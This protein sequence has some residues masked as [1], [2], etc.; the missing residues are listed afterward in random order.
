VNRIARRQRRRGKIKQ[1]IRFRLRVWPYLCRMITTLL[2]ADSIPHRLFPVEGYSDLEARTQDLE[3]DD[4]ASLLSPFPQL[5]ATIGDLPYDSLLIL[6]YL[7]V[8]LHTH[9]LFHSCIPSSCSRSALSSRSPPTS[10]LASTPAFTF[11]SWTPTA[12]GTWRTSLAVGW[13]G[14]KG[15][16]SG[17]TTSG[18]QERW[19][20]RGRRLRLWK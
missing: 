5:P 20:R 10:S 8:S 18:V 3:T 7:I 14:E 6:S 13:K 9:V 11:T 1:L 2:I 4:E 17:E 19:K 15:S 12:H 16:G